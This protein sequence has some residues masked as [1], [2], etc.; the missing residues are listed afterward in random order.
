MTLLFMDGFKASD[1]ASK[2][3]VIGAGTPTVGT[4][5]ARVTNGA[6]FYNAHVSTAMSITKAFTA[7]SEVWIGIAIKPSNASTAWNISLHGDSAGT[8]HLTIQRNAGGAL[9]VRR[10]TSTGT[11]L[12]TGA[13]TIADDTWYM[14]EVNATI[15]DS[16]GK[17]NVYINGSAAPDISY[18]GDTK[19]AGTNT[20]ID[21]LR[22][23][24]SYGSI[25]RITDVYILNTAGSAPLNTQ[26]GDVSVRTLLPS[27][28]G[29]TSQL[30]GS[31]GNSTDNYALV[32]EI[33]ISSADYV[34]S[35]TG[36]QY[37]TYAMNDLP[38]GV[39]NVY[40]CAWNGYLAKSDAGAISAAPVIRS[41]GTDYTG[42]TLALPTSY[43]TQQVIYATDPATS[44]AWATSAVD[45]VE[46]GMMV[47]A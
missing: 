39:T 2:W 32:D 28:N 36:D 43:A 45:A 47:K 46:A 34:G 6:Y 16:G 14:I 38:A 11:V 7:S 35:S 23:S 13:A 30:T 10:G 18:T 1:Y 24:M 40:A 25:I 19:N 17:C 20:T 27:G 8:Q 44:S 29:T 31:D 12:A 33:P 22:L 3:T 4:T 21:A 9:E 15:A 5:S 26:L 41:D 37:D 42:S